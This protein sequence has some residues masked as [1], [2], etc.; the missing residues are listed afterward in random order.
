MGRFTLQKISFWA[1]AAFFRD[2]KTK[3]RVAEPL[4]CHPV[5]YYDLTLRGDYFFSSFFAA[6][7]SSAF[8]AG[9]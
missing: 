2:E 5:P 4:V 1:P 8:F 3:S 9:L 6:G 7:F